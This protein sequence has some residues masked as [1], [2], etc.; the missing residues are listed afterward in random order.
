MQVNDN[1]R[2]KMNIY[3]LQILFDN[4]N[5]LCLMYLPIWIEETSGAVPASPDSIPNLTT[6]GKAVPEIDGE[7]TITV[8]SNENVQLAEMD[9]KGK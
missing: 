4:I 5:I 6:T 1:T 8:A 3:L 2:F 7:Q 9:T